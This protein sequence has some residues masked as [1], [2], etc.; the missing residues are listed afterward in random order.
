MSGPVSV[1]RRDGVA[2]VVIDNPP[3]N[4]LSHGLRKPLHEAIRALS[5]DRSI[6]AIV[7]ACAGRTFAAGADI[8]EFG[9][10]VERPHLPDLIEAL[11]SAGKPTVAAIHGTALGGGLELAL[12]CAFRVALASARLGLPE[13]KL[14]LLPG[15][16]GTV[17][18]PRLVGPSKS[19]A[20]IVSGEPIGAEEALEHGLVDEVFDADL[21]GNAAEFAAQ[22]A[23]EGE[24]PRPARAREEKLFAARTDL[25]AFDAEIA[26]ALKKT[27]GLAA[28]RACAAAVRNALTLPFDE[29]LAAERAAFLALVASDESRAQRHLFFA[30]REA[31]KIPGLTPDIRPRGIDRVG[32]VGAGTM[33]GGI[34]LSF[35]ATGLPVTLVEADSQALERGV[36]R[37]RATLDASVA[38]G[39]LD[40]AERDRRLALIAPTTD[41]S[42]LA[43][44]DL[45]VEAAYEDMAVKRDIFARLDALAKP[46]AIL[47]TNTSY[48]DVDAIASAT[49]RPGDVLGLHFF[50]PAN[51]MRLLEVVRGGNTAPDVLAT[52][53][54]LARRIGKIPVVAG[55]CHGFIGNRMLAARSAE[56]ENLL[57]E[58]ATPTTV[59]AAFAG[60]GFPMGPFAMADLAGLDIGRANRKALGKTAIVADALCEA[61][62]LGQKTGRGYHRYDNARTPAPDPEV[63]ALIAAKSAG[64]GMTRRAI[65]AAEI[66]ERT[67]YPMVGE[68]AKILAEGIALRASD[69]DLVWVHGYGFPVGKGGPMFW[70]DTQGLASIVARLDHWR[71][72]T[73]RAVFD[74]PPLLRELAAAGRPLAAV[75]NLK[76]AQP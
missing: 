71:A 63:E 74:A 8:R 5:A 64:A 42:A 28:P 47:A 70:A 18:L 51:V 72:A 54:A 73:G 62:W 35:V 43:D 33:G 59:D 52:A 41:L 75:S 31:A 7:L 27:R 36:A 30:E 38:R 13:V 66:L 50:S 23:A 57:L 65:D 37:I 32:V 3:V 53:V 20:M 15:A 21:I 19:L 76:G 2:V 22:L 4:A 56:L 58:G 69:I 48:L 68:A 55:V 6:A 17:R 67:L 44:A 61:G 24:P 40:E 49:T 1:S 46:G 12:G 34:A 25:D 45:V 29:A 11:E 26:A 16:G 14:G 39:S 9:K 10:P 60:F